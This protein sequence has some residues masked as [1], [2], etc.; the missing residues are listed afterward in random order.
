MVIAPRIPV[1]ILVEAQARGWSLTGDVFRAAS[2][3][4]YYHTQ[5]GWLLGFDRKHNRYVA[6]PDKR[7]TTNRDR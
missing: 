1:L 4:D 5:H 7:T 3:I 6:R 2:G